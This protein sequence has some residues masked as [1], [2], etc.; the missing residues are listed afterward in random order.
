MESAS[1]V[2]AYR[3]G[4][5]FPVTRPPLADAYVVVRDGT[6]VSIATQRPDAD[7][8]VDWADRAILPGLVNCHAHLEFSDLAAPLGRAGLPFPTWIGEV[9]AHRRRQAE[10][11]DIVPLSARIERGLAECVAAGTVL[12]GEIATAPWPDV[13]LVGQELEV[14]AFRELLGLDPERADELTL[15]GAEQLAAAAPAGLHWGLSPH[16]PYTVP[17][18][19]LTRLAQLAAR[20]RAPLAMHLAESPEEGELLATHGGPFRDL[21]ELVGAWHPTAIPRG[22]RYLDY[23][24]CLSE[25]GRTLVIHGN[26]LTDEDGAWLARHSGT[27]SVVYCPRTHAY[28]GHPPH[29]FRRLRQQG[30]RVALGT[31]SR[32]SNP[33][34]SLFAELRWLADH[35]P[36]VAPSDLLRMATLEGATALGFDHAYG[37]LEPGKRA[38]FTCL[39]LPAARTQD[40]YELLWSSG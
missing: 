17:F 40:P 2:V 28:F 24:R 7:R 14:V 15:R 36:D 19:A 35:C 23:L 18:D 8:I 31:D 33:D 38:R 37:S 25:S 29:P 26:F 34:L 1:P 11:G 12:L 30:V 16:A 9:I 13:P 39:P 27:M 10:A 21:L 22:V 3:A 6:I 32:A 20:H 5:V 4:Y